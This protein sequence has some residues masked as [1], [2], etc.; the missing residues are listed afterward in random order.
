LAAGGALLLAGLLLVREILARSPR[1][2][3]LGALGWA[4]AARRPARS[5]TTAALVASAVFLLV[6]AGASRQ[7]PAPR[8]SAHDSGSGGFELLGRTSLPVL[9]DLRSPEGRES[10]GLAGEELEGVELLALRVRDGDEASCLN[11]DRPRSPRLLG[12][13]V[14][15]LSGRFRF[16]AML[17][18]RADPWTLLEQDLGPE[19]VPAVVDAVSLQWTLQRRLGDELELLDGRGRPF[20]ARIV[21]ALSDSILQGDVILA[22]G[23]FERLFPDEAGHRAFL[24][25]VPR[26]RVAAL[27]GRLSRALAD[28]GLS[29]VPTHERLDLLHGVQNT[30][31]SIFQALGGLGLM[32][33]SAGLLA[34]VLRVAVERKGE[35]ALLAALGFSRQELRRL[36]LFEQGGLVG[37]GL[38]IGALAGLAVALPRAE[39]SPRDALAAVAA[40]LA[41]VGLCGTAWVWLGARLALRGAFSAEL[42][43]E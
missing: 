32:L 24:L 3:A 19:L 7:G 38:A 8:E 16:A 6:V 11:L 25:D 12:A 5:L 17:E 39:A 13:R 10:Y 40:L 41:A 1:P 9:H 35:L 20:R 23:A 42:K 27:A 22:E 36:L 28:E 26:E 33:G 30:Y 34:L 43:R 15:G 31:L 18:P 2:R 21:A 29:L 14:S 37:S 4:N